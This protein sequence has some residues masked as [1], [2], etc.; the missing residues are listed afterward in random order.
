MR[1]SPKGRIIDLRRRQDIPLLS[2]TGAR[3]HPLDLTTNRVGTDEFANESQ[4]ARVLAIAQTLSTGRIC[5]LQI[6]PK[7][8]SSPTPIETCPIPHRSM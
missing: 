5:F 4:C 6:E 8:S 1:L 3:A 7:A 2:R